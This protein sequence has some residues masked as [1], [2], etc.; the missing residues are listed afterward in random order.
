MAEGSGNLPPGIEKLSEG[1]YR[2]RYRGPDGHR[3]STP[4]YT[5]PAEAKFALDAA[6]GQI[7]NG[8]WLDPRRAGIT[9]DEWFALWMPTRLTSGR[10]KRTVRPYVLDKDWARYRNHI[11]PYLGRVALI[12]LTT[13]RVEKWH[14]QLAT[15]GRKLPTIC[16]AHALLKTALDRAVTDD[17]LHKNPAAK[18]DPEAAPAPSWQLV[19][20][21]QFDALLSEVPERYRPVVL[22]A[23]MAGLRWSEIV[24]LTRQDYNPLRGELTVSKGTVYHKGA[25]VDGPTK[26]RRDR[27]IPVVGA[28]RAA[29]DG[30]V[31]A[32]GMAADARLFT[33]PRGNVLRHPHFME[34]VYKP[35]AVR[36]GLGTYTQRDG[37]KRYEGVRF[38]DLRH[39]FVS[40]LMADGVPPH[41][42]KELAGHATITTTEK[43]A[44]TNQ[45]E[46]AA[47]MLRAL[48]G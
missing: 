31:K 5:K 16:K 13:F 14:G 25:L 30:H 26:S 35:A 29:L 32:A 4:I 21:A 27:T 17:R 46:L 12:D 37:R 15:D 6:K 44:H 2:G 45:D 38:H 36:A 20:R 39:S 48:G 19:T 22:V 3:H 11:A 34:R 7:T 28:L 40:W 10:R 42:V 43:Y 1:R 9:L 8:T 23:A 41:K 33:S 47:A 18:T 24:G